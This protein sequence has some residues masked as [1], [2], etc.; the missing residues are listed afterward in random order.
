M[1]K[2]WSKNKKTGK[3]KLG[4]LHVPRRLD[5]FEIQLR[6]EAWIK[7]YPH[8]E[9]IY[10]DGALCFEWKNNEI[11]VSSRMTDRQYMMWCLKYRDL[12]A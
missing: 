3:R 4:S 10:Q 5:D 7:Q 11:V 8:L 6:C 12:S 9:E 1:V 2:L